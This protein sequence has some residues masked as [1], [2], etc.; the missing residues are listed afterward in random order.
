M[1]CLKERYHVI[2]LLF[3]LLLSNQVQFSYDV[4]FRFGSDVAIDDI[5]LAGHPLGEYLI[6]AINISM[7]VV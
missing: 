3:L 5:E 6:L 1:Y 2:I 4:E 7:E